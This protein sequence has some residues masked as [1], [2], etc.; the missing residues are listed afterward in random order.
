MRSLPAVQRDG[1]L[2]GTRPLLVEIQ[3]LVDHSMM[4]NPDVAVGLEQ[5]V[6]QS[7]L[8][9]CCTDTAVTANVGSGRLRQR[10][11]RREVTET[12]ARITETAAGDGLQPA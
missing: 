6:W 9:R 11:R 4:A 2:E 3:A 1:R 5:T 10:G 7:L 12:S 8:W